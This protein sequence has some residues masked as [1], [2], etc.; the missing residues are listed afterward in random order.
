MINIPTPPE[1]TPPYGLQIVI[2]FLPPSSNHIYVNGRG[3]RGRFLSKEAEAWKNRFMQQVVAPYMMPISEFCKT[4]VKDPSSILE[5]HMAFFFENDDLLNTTFGKGGKSAAKTRYKK[6]D[7][8]N[9]IKLVTDAVSKAIALDD[10]LHFREIHDKCSAD[11]VGGVGVCIRLKKG[12]LS[13]YGLPP[14]VETPSL[15]I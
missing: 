3:G 11:M 9:R 8:Q 13:F 10:S 15:P 7:V 2:P 4:V 6:M 5:L 14:F 12:N 1:Y